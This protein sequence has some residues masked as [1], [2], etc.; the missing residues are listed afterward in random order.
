MTQE[1]QSS[2]NLGGDHYKRDSYH[3]SLENE[4]WKPGIVP[5]TGQ[6]G[7]KRKLSLN[8]FKSW[9]TA[10]TWLWNLT[11]L[12]IITC[13]RYNARTVGNYLF[14][15]QAISLTICRIVHTWA[16][17]SR[18]PPV[19]C[20]MCPWEGDGI[21]MKLSSPWQPTI[22]NNGCSSTS[23]TLWLLCWGCH[24]WRCLFLT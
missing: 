5:N 19:F 16:P 8:F 1:C 10:D 18:A 17:W 2:P 14:I 6:H 15:L 20:S 22:W 13:V 12:L 4:V 3:C 21:H 9:T 23:I 7:G 24:F 11:W